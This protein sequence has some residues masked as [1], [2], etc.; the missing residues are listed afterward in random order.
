[1]SVVY[2]FK[3]LPT[4]RPCYLSCCAYTRAFSLPTSDLNARLIVTSWNRYW[5]VPYYWVGCKKYDVV[6]G[7]EDMESSYLL[8]KGKPFEAFPMLKPDGLVGT[9]V[10]YDG[11][12]DLRS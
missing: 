12:S 3:R 5:Q 6:A 9:L 1:M 2:F 10:Y 7:E 4:S 8:S 11:M